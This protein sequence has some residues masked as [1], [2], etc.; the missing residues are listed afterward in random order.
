MSK[1]ERIG[2]EIERKYVI[3]I[4][5]VSELS[6]MPE[7][8]SSE[9]VQIYLPKF[10]GATHRVRK[11]MKNSHAVYTETKKVRIDNM[12]S[13]E[14]EREISDEEFFALSLLID[15]NTRPINKTRHTFVYKNQ[16]FEIDIYPEWKRTA[17]LETELPTRDTEVEF[18]DF[19]RIIEDVTG[20]PAY[21]NA[22]MARSF[23]TESSYL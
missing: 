21:S 13:R 17:I 23:P 3:A 2:V 5:D 15:P 11:R 4:P 8:T 14:Y 20:N 22:A 16:M 18:P 7:Y 6:Q 19:I 10:D 9:I 1:K 12:S